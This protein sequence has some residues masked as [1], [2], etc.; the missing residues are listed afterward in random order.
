MSCDSQYCPGCNY[1]ALQTQV[2]DPVER[3]LFLGEVIYG[4]PISQ[5]SQDVIRK[6]FAIAGER[7]L[8][9]QAPVIETAMQRLSRAMQGNLVCDVSHEALLDAA[10]AAHR[11]WA[12]TQ[13]S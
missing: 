5:A 3:T 4:T 6:I 12:A 2:H 1:K 9:K 11:A 13:A 7:L 10:N 8:L